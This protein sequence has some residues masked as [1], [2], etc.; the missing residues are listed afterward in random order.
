MS[1]KTSPII[2][3]QVKKKSCLF[4]L[5]SCSKS[6]KPFTVGKKK[7]IQHSCKMNTAFIALLFADFFLKY[8]TILLNLCS[9]LA[10]FPSI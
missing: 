7:L 5:H 9:F 1:F 8:D 4:K 3:L 6:L 2:F 10:S